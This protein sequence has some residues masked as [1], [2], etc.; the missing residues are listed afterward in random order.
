MPNFARLTFFINISIKV[1][2]Y[3]GRYINPTDHFKDG[4]IM[5]SIKT[6]SIHSV[7]PLTVLP[8]LYNGIWLLTPKSSTILKKRKHFS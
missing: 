4:Y 2:V 5:L 8:D 3:F 1:V 6:V 7:C